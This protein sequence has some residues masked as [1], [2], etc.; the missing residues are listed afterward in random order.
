MVCCFLFS[1][2]EFTSELIKSPGECGGV[3]RKH[4]AVKRNSG[5]AIESTGA[6]KISSKESRICIFRRSHEVMILQGFWAA[7]VR[8]YDTS[9][10]LRVFVSSGRP[11]LFCM[12]QTESPRREGSSNVF[13]RND[14]CL[15]CVFVRSFLWFSM[16]SPR[17]D[18][19]LKGESS[20]TVNSVHRQPMK[21]TETAGL[22]WTSLVNPCQGFQ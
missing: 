13:L 14:L 8:S 9:E 4:A 16:L 10:F 12:V 1:V 17:R 5:G 11:R 22:W 6:R 18:K 3:E 2:L 21:V 20:R 19:D 7:T 15:L